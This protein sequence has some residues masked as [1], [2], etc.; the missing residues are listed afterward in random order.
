[1]TARADKD[2]LAI[3]LETYEEG[4]KTDHEEMKRADRVLFVI[5][6]ASDPS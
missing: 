2:P 3:H 6:A 5:D 1:M 4:W